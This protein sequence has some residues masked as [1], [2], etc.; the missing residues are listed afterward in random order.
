MNNTQF[1]WQADDDQDLG[2]PSSQAGDSSGRGKRFWF[3]IGFILLSAILTLLLVR[4]FTQRQRKLEEIVRQDAGA[5]FSLWQEAVERKDNELY[6][7]LLGA[8]DGN[9]RRVQNHLFEND[10]L[11]KRPFLGL[12]LRDENPA[13]PEIE[14][15]PDLQ[16]ATVS[17]E[18][19]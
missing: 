5:S 15:A 14:L 13:A 1:E 10:M 3:V 8:E 7:Q 12:T 9:W 17:F 2:K 18:R 4:F 6:V 11:L 19:I 16:R